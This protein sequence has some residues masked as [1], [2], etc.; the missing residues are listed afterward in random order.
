[1]L[2]KHV[3]RKNLKSAQ[4]YFENNSLIQMICMK[5]MNFLLKITLLVKFSLEFNKHVAPNK[6]VLEGKISLELISVQHVY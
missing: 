2:N 3:G 4:S 1:M 6:G 5:L